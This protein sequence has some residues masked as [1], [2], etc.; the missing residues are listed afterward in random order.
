MP[1]TPRGQGQGGPKPGGFPSGTGAD[2]KLIALFILASAA[3]IFLPALDGTAIRFAAGLAMVLFVPGYA[4]VAAMFPGRRDIGA[5][6]RAAL[7]FGLS[8]VIAFIA[9]MGLNL[10][11]W[12]IRLDPL[13]ACLAAFS[14]ICALVAGLRRRALAEGERF[15]VDARGACQSLMGM[16]FPPD[17]PRLDRAL[18][19]ALVLAAL[20]AVTA[21]AYSIAAPKP[22]ERFTE[23]YIL[24]PDGVAGSYPTNF[25]LGDL[26]PITVGVVNHEYRNVAYGLVVQLNDSRGV[27][28]LREE[29]LA[30]AHNQTWTETLEIMPDRAGKAMKLEVLL[31]ADGN[32]TSP[33]RECHLWVDVS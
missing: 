18:T 14:A 16:A 33:Y 11:A 17:E 15:D 27:T 30:L 7:S 28:A 32:T 1:V 31:Y 6:E 26:E 2:L 25:T 19:I 23:L 13:V 21:W 8:I 22:G 9:G 5:F 12:G 29:K 10:T 20:V 3:I 4:L 24:G